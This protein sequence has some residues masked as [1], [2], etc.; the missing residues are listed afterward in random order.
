[1]RPNCTNNQQKKNRDD[2]LNNAPVQSPIDLNLHKNNTIP[3]V[4]ILPNGSFRT[5]NELSLLASG[6][7]VCPTVCNSEIR[8]QRE[9]Y[10]LLQHL[11]ELLLSPTMGQCQGEGITITSSGGKLDEMKGEHMCYI[12]D[13]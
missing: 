3:L 12:T 4:E 1:M 7:F 11:L 2:P 6:A 13:K 8:A 10:R 9:L 5:T